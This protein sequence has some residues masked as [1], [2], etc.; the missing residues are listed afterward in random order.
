MAN[1]NKIKEEIKARRKKAMY[2]NSQKYLAN[3]LGISESHLCNILAGRRKADEKLNQEIE[4]F[5]KNNN[6]KY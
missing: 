3:K 6:L 4:Y 5:S 1:K 2:L